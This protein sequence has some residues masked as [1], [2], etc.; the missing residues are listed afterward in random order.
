MLTS[1]IPSPAKICESIIRVVDWLKGFFKD[2]LARAPIWCR[3]LA[4]DGIGVFTCGTHI[5]HYHAIKFRCLLD[6][7][8]PRI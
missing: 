2:I 6:H 5:A 3:S 1:Q 8:W 7:F 4:P